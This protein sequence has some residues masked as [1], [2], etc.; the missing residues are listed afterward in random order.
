MGRFKKR[1]IEHFGVD[2][3][4]AVITALSWSVLFT[5]SAGS[6]DFQ[7]IDKD[8]QIVL[9]NDVS[10]KWSRYYMVIDMKTWIRLAFIGIW[11]ISDD[12]YSPPRDF[13]EVTGQGLILRG[14]PDWFIELATKLLIKIEYFTRIDV[15]LDLVNVSVPYIY[16]KI[17]KE[18][19]KKSI[20]KIFNDKKEWKAQTIYF[21]EKS[22][23]KNTYQLIRI[24]DKKADSAGDK[25]KTY[26]YPQ[27]EKY[28]YVTRFEI[29]LRED[30]AKFWTID[31]LLDINYIFAVMVKKFYKYNYQFFGF[32]KFDDF[33][34]KKKEEKSIHKERV[35][36]IQERKEHMEKFG[37]SFKSD[38]QRL[39]WITTFATYWNRLLGEGI[40]QEMLLSYLVHVVPDTY[41]EKYRDEKV[42]LAIDTEEIDRMRRGIAYKYKKLKKELKALEEEEKKYDKE[43]R[44][45]LTRKIKNALPSP[46][47]NG[48]SLFEEMA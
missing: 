47:V 42:G 1:G 11:G 27:H 14:W 10:D 16:E 4:R 32:L 30:L 7:Q 17:L 23:E 31:K 22:K 28:E 9:L 15:C 2:Y 25:N 43:V 19:D 18:S 24:Y 40:S 35:V 13:F 45:F 44:D 38:E 12:S 26:L 3:F 21:W 39:L 8:T 36:K 41:T 34:K 6:S 48:V 5:L 46:I 37:S 20:S 29:E 33:V